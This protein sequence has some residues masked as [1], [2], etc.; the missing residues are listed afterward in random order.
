MFREGNPSAKAAR[1]AIHAIC[2]IANFSVFTYLSSINISN[3]IIFILSQDSNTTVLKANLPCLVR[4]H[5]QRIRDILA[6]ASELN[7]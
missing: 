6:F 7:C 5:L 4:T 3:I 1:A 2:L